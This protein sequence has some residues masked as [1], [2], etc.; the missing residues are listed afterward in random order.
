MT[1]REKVVEGLK[2]CAGTNNLAEECLLVCPYKKAGCIDKLMFDALELLKPVKPKYE[3]FFGDQ[4]VRCG[5]CDT[6]IGT[7]KFCSKCG[8][9]VKRE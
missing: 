2:Q 5:F 7:S 9:E 4:I 3:D 1:D 6:Y 8:R